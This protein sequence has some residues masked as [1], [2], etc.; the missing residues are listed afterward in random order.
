MDLYP[1]QVVY[2]MEGN[3][4]QCDYSFDADG[5]VA[6]GDP[7]AVETS[8]TPVESSETHE[9]FRVMACNALPLQESAYDA[10]SG[11]LKI[12]IIK[13]GLNKSKARFYPAETLKRDFHVFEGAKMFADHQSDKE[14]KDKPEGSVNNWVASLK[15]V[16]AESDG[17]L[18]GD[19]FVIDPPFKA[20]LDALNKQ[21]LLHEM[22]VSI[23]AIGEASEQ[24]REGVTTNVVE[25]LIAAR[26]VDFVT[27]A[28]AGGQIE[29][30]ESATQDNLNDVDLVT[31]AVLRQRR[32]DLI[33]L[34]EKHAQEITMK[35]VEQQLQESQAQVATL[36]TAN[37]DLTTKFEEAQKTAAKATVSAEITKLLSES[38]L[39]A[40]SQD[41]VRKQ[42]AEATEVKGIAE[43]IKE[44]QDYVKQLGGGKSAPKNLGAA[45]N[46]T[47]RES[48]TTDHKANLEEAFKLMP[49]MSDKDAKLAAR[50]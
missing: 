9:S 34:V 17:T 4:F 3:L 2:S 50:L 33:S 47:T 21:G 42:F 43:A 15:N 19:A 32:P 25:S 35:S 23:R 49:G 38:K 10:A 36:T 26:S 41:R 29:A 8:Y 48:D 30:M 6:L 37:K 27:Y 16:H 5:D 45:D 11:K 20:K 46:G 39:P 24:E 31:E 12:T 1:D 14:A 7:I 13:P 22:G 44:E 28:G 40:I 18:A